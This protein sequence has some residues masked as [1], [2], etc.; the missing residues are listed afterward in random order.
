M[1]GHRTGVSWRSCG[2]TNTKVATVWATFVY[3]SSPS[4][5]SSGVKSS[6]SLSFNSSSNS[7]S[8]SN[9][10][11]SSCM[12]KMLLL[13]CLFHQKRESLQVPPYAPVDKHASATAIASNSSSRRFLVGRTSS[14]GTI[15]ETA[16][17]SAFPYPV[18]ASFT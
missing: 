8:D 17:L 15:F 4:S 16:T 3:I 5:D 14:L 10:S 12:S 9:S 7:S 11:S 6:R 13:A 1:S 2:H 18:T